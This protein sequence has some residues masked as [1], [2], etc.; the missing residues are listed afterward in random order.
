MSKYLGR[1]E[2]ERFKGILR[3]AVR[4]STISFGFV[5]SLL[6]KCHFTD[7]L[8]EFPIRFFFPRI[9]YVRSYLLCLQRQHNPVYG[10]LAV[11]PYFYTY[12]YVVL[13]CAIGFV[14]RG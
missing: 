4:S 12:L 8:L 11:S 6:I 7:V 1:L 13:T 14:R 10:H 2:V 9:S 3:H 5:M